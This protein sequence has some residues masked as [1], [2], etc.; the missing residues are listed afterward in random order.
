MLSKMKNSLELFGIIYHLVNIHLGI[1]SCQ[2]HIF[3]T[4]Q[5]ILSI[6]KM[7]EVGTELKCNRIF[8]ICIDLCYRLG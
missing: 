8:I 6:F 4:K 7:S 5:H 2:C 3:L 1:L